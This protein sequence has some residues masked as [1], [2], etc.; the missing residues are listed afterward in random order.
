MAEIAIRR[1]GPDDAVSIAAIHEAAVEDERRRGH[2]SDRQI[3]AWAHP[4]SLAEL[5]A[6]L[7]ARR[8]FIAETSV[9]SAAYAQL[10]LENATLRSIYVRPEYRRRG[11]GRRLADTVLEAARAAGLQRLEL[12]S[13]LNAVRFYEALGFARIGDVE[14]ELRRGVAMPCVRMARDILDESRETALPDREESPANLGV[15]PRADR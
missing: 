10:D 14:H 12:D 13:S 3:D 6:Q 1:A 7:R 9:A 8:F 5:R 15:H 11:L 2:Y 4:R